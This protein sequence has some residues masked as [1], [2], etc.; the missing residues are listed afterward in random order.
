MLL[1]R[2]ASEMQCPQERI[3]SNDSVGRENPA[4]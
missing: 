2:R 4:M 3:N 1:R